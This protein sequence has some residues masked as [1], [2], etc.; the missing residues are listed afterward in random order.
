MGSHISGVQVDH[1][2]I[3]ECRHCFLAANLSGRLQS[4]NEGLL[5]S[6]LGRFLFPSSSFR[7]WMVNDSISFPSR[8]TG[9]ASLELTEVLGIVL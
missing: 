7:V 5:V 2:C 3:P 4:S 6:L 1:Q 8:R 9:S